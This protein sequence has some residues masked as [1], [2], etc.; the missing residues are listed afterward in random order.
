M[1]GASTQI[2]FLPSGSIL[3]DKFEMRIASRHYSLYVHSYLDYGGAAAGA[4]IEEHLTH[5]QPHKQHI[6]QPCLPKGKGIC[7]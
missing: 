7:T 1:G 2:A 6:V 5:Q 3:S 4:W